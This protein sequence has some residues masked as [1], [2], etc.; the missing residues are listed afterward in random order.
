MPAMT[1][2]RIRIRLLDCFSNAFFSSSMPP[3]S[4]A[5]APLSDTASLGPVSYTHLDVYKR[6]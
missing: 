5:F 1:T 2:H 6:Q 4:P 3:V